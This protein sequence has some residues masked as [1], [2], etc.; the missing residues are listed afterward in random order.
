MQYAKFQLSLRNLEELLYKRGIGVSY[1][2]VRCC[3]GRGLAPSSQVFRKS[4]VKW[5]FPLVLQF[6]MAGNLIENEIAALLLLD[7]HSNFVRSR[8]TLDLWEKSKI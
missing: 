3:R 7:A 6:K 5:I 1:K 8:A 2:S 4:E